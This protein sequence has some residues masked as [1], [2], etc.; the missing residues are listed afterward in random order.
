MSQQAD[1]AAI[2]VTY[3]TGPRLSECLHA[4]RANKAISE[5]IIVDNGNPPDMTNWILN[6]SAVR[7]D[8]AAQQGPDIKYIKTHGNIGFG[9]A[10][11]IGAA[12]ASA[13]NLL[14]INP[15]CVMRPDALEPLFAAADGLASPWIVGGRIFDLSGTAQRGPRRQELTLMRALSKLVGGAGINLPLEPQP[16]GPIPVDVIS[17]AFFLIDRDGFHQIGGFDEDYFL[18][19]EDIDLCKRVHLAGGD[20][21]YQPGAGALHYGAT[22]AVSKRIVERHKAA[23]FA[24]YF[25][26]FAKNPLHRL[27]AELCIPLIFAGLMIRVFLSGRR[28]PHQ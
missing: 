5:L 1:V 24:R 12:K 28:G 22:S 19:V 11:N 7:T 15:D 21:V 26:K 27:A 14:I 16:K 6:F 2:V 17:G 25:R 10:V 20:V 18:H 4:L 8:S 23:G 13:S 3:L 9:S